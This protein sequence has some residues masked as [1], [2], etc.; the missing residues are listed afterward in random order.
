MRYLIVQPRTHGLDVASWML[1]DCSLDITAKT[2]ALQLH[3]GT[4]SQDRDESIR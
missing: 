1:L 4:S 3:S 2:P